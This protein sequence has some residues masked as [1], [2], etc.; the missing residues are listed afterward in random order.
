[1]AEAAG[2]V[3]R[4]EGVNFSSTVT[5]TQDISVIRGAGLALLHAAD[6]VQAILDAKLGQGVAEQVFAGA[7]QAAFR[8][9]ADSET[10]TAVL[11]DLRGKLATEGEDPRDLAGQLEAHGG[12]PTA[13]MREGMI[14][15]AHLSFVCD[16]AHDGEAL[17]DGDKQRDALDRALYAAEARNRTRQMQSLTVPL[18]KFEQGVL[19]FDPVD[20]LRPAVPKIP[21]IAKQTREAADAQ[22]VPATAAPATAA[23]RLYGRKMRKAFYGVELGEPID[24][25]VTESVAD[26]CAVPICGWDRFGVRPSLQNKLAIFYADGNGFGA[27]RADL[28]QHHEPPRMV[29]ALAQFSR[30]L[31]AFRRGFLNRTLEWLRTMGGDDIVRQGRGRVP[32]RIKD[33][34]EL[35]LRLETLLW[36][37]DEF[38]MVV[39]GWLGFTL[40]QGFFKLSKDWKIGEKTLTHGA[41]LLFCDRKTPI[42]DITRLVKEGLAEEAKKHRKDM[43]ALSVAAF[44][45]A[46]LPDDLGAYRKRLYPNLSGPDAW[47]VLT[48]GELTGLL[49]LIQRMGN[50][51]EHARADRTEFPRSQL[52]KLLRIAQQ[53]TPFGGNACEDKVCE[54]LR[55]YLGNAGADCAVGADDFKNWGGDRPL[56]LTLALIAEYWDYA[57][58]FLEGPPTPPLTMPGTGVRS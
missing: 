35:R 46:D 7:S 4:V 25:P 51:G 8:F 10:A 43:N 11:H 34:E 42:R 3:L 40:A 56:A 2:Y 58:P 14:P 50:K 31:Q 21:G 32:I 45:S 17:P 29:N 44:E 27:I 1:M 26:I 55:E 47:F 48:A 41:G 38:T 28:A 52:Y 53:T 18:P 15:L 49:E 9:R 5:D 22:G 6:R 37:G 30:E 54:S 23:R 16:L 24:E 39:P 13:T 20:K 12:D 19:G 36:G 57:D 33:K